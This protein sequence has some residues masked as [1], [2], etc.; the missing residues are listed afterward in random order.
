MKSLKLVALLLFGITLLAM[1]IFEEYREGL[2]LALG[3]FAA[4]LFLID[5][6]EEESCEGEEFEEY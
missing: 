2:T 1:T 5:L 6:R 4:A 3:L